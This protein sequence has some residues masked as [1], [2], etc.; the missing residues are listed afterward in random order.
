MV[1][2]K[3]SLVLDLRLVRS[4]VR[5]RALSLWSPFSAFFLHCAIILDG[6]SDI[7]ILIGVVV[8]EY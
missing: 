8:A 5:V 1:P 2:S 7:D 3:M 4:R 6:S